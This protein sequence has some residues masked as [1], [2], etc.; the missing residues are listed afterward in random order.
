MKNNKGFSLVELIVV[1]AIMAILAAVAIPTFATFITKANVA[2]DVSFVN[3]LAYAAK[4]AHTASGKEVTDV[5]VSIAADG[6]I[7]ASYKV[8]GVDVTIAKGDNGVYA[9]TSSDDATEAAAADTVAA[10]DW[11]YKFKKYDDSADAWKLSDN[12]K[13]LVDATPAAGA[14]E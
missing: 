7:G 14:G 11:T 5:Q 2:S 6:T 8:G 3:D 13:E 4:I 10:I 9:A 1:I 12:G